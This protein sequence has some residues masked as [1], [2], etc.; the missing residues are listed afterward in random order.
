MKRRSP[1]RKKNIEP[2]QMTTK[3]S[4]IWRCTSLNQTRALAAKLA[5]SENLP[6]V[7]LLQGSLGSGKT[8]FARAVLR[9]LGY[10][11]SVTSPT[12]VL[13]H[14]F[15]V[16]HQQWNRVVHVDAYR[17]KGPHEEAALDLSAAAADPKCLL[18]IEWPEKLQGHPGR[19]LFTIKFS[20][21]RVGRKITLSRPV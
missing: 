16:G 7:W 9:A 13:R 15:S 5:R 21:Q 14:D 6:N 4:R 8:T 1:P 19:R 2:Y 11:R 17:I 20:H 18:L 3:S 10:R 12:F